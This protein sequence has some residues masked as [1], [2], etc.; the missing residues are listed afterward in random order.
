MGGEKNVF[1]FFVQDLLT[2]QDNFPSLQEFRVEY[3]KNVN[4]LH[5]CHIT[6]AIPAWPKNQA[7]INN[8]LQKL[9]SLHRNFDYQLSKD[10]IFDL[11]KMQCKQFYKLFIEAIDIEPTAIKS[12]QKKP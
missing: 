11:R 4:F 5:Y 12:W 3:N 9:S 1:F 6:S 10:I 2:S 8:D 7:S